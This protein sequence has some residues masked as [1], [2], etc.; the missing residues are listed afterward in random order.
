MAGVLL[1]PFRHHRWL[2][3]CFRCGLEWNQGFVL[4]VFH[5]LDLTCRYLRGADTGDP[6]SG[7]TTRIGCYPPAKE[8]AYDEFS[9]SDF[10]FINWG[11]QPW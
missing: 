11:K 4:F 9:S 6:H 1:F 2:G 8:L 5:Q 3:K 10:E 7:W